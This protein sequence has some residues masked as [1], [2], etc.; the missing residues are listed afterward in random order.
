[1]SH[2]P[3]RRLVDKLGGDADRRK[4]AALRRRRS[5]IA[6]V[7]VS[8]CIEDERRAAVDPLLPV[9]RREADVY[10]LR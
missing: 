4:V 3:E 10:E 8:V 1:M 2:V 6:D 9:A 7:T 5:L